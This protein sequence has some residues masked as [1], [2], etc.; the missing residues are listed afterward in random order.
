MTHCRRIVTD[1]ICHNQ[2]SHTIRTYMPPIRVE[3]PYLDGLDWAVTNVR[4][5]L[6]DF[7]DNIFAFDYPA[8]NWVAA[9][10]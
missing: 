4:S 10:R 2:P 3:A 7:G 9:F 1:I 5:S 8:K 6:A